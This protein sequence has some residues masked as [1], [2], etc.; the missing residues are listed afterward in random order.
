[1]TLRALTASRRLG[2]AGRTSEATAWEKRR[3]CPS[4]WQNCVMDPINVAL[5]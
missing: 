5:S 3:G 1:M 4:R 2:L